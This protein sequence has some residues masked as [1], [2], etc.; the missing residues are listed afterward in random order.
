MATIGMML[1]SSMAILAI[2]H[3]TDLVPV[4]AMPAAILDFGPKESPAGQ[5]INKQPDGS[6]AVWI[7]FSGV[8]PADLVV[9]FNGARL[10]TQVGEK[11]ITATVPKAQLKDPGARLIHLEYRTVHEI[12]RSN[13][14]RMML[15]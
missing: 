3:S 15:Q 8:P 11:L 6:S 4:V 1:M 2:S 9:V 10:P 7:V 12:Q 13:T 5:R 14:V